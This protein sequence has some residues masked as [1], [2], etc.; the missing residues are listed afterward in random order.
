MCRATV[1]VA[2]S[3]VPRTSR[4]SGLLKLQP[5]S[6]EE[7][8]WSERSGRSEMEVEPEAALGPK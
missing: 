6:K 1:A 4:D 5:A 3:A 2:A 7:R 8:D